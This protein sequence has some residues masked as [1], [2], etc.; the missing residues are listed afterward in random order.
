VT[1][2]TSHLIRFLQQ[3]NRTLQEEN[4][5]LRDEC[6]A[7]RS[8]VKSLDELYWAAQ[9][10]STEENLLNLL[11]EILFHAMSLVEAED[12]SLMLLDEKANDLVFAVVHGDAGG[13]LRG[14][15]ISADAGVAGWVTAEGKPAVV[16][17]PRQ[18]WRFSSEVDESFGFFT[19]SL[20]SVPMI[21]GKKTVGVINALNKRGGDEFTEADAT[22]LSVFG[23]VA[24]TVLESMRMRIDAEEAS[25]SPAI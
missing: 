2:S 24:A 7:L 11:D 9:R 19:R 23:H 20:V 21:T 10:I 6:D 13:Y 22:L 17:D 8:Y 25:A 15:R 4:K 18:D 12:G 16:N 14:F 5:T 3:E 1:E